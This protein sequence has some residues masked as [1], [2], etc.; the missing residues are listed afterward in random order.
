MN[1]LTTVMMISALALGYESAS[2]APPKNDVPSVVVRFADLDLTHSDG[3]GVL[4]RRLKSAA[5]T[6]CA[7]Q[8]G[9]DLRSQT[10]YKICWQ[11]ALSTAVAKVDQASLTAYHQAQFKGR[12]ATFQIAQ[13]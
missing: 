5:E 6:V 11:S 10:R 2:A 12:N 13:K 9:R 3:V 1:R 7:P 4:Y 8:N